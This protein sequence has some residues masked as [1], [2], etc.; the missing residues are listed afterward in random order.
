[1]EL[2]LI[3]PNTEEWEFIWTWLENHPINDGVEDPS[4]ALHDG[5]AWQYMG[6]FKQKDKVIS[7]FRHRNHPKINGLSKLSVEHPSFNEESISK[8]FKL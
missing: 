8:K 5:E 2:I 6:S 7:E 1:M 3:T 4:T